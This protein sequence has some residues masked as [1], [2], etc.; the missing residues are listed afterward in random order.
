MKRNL[1]YITDCEGPICLNDNAQ[2]LSEFYLP[3][4]D[5]FFEQ[6]SK[7]DDIK[8]L[9][10]KT[11]DYSAGDTLRL[12]LPFFRAYGVSNKGIEYFVRNIKRVDFLNGVKKAFLYLH[13]DGFPVFIVST[14]YEQF[15]Y[16]VADELGIDQENVY[17]TKLDLDEYFFSKQEKE[18]IKDFLYEIISLPKI[19]V[20][21]NDDGN[22]DILDEDTRKTFERLEDIFWKE[23]NGM[24]CGLLLKDV[25]VMNANRKAEA[26]KEIL[27]KRKGTQ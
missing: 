16:I 20:P 19:N 10:G 14:S 2:E 5:I 1:V 7:Y 21:E 22:I 23:M 6:I 17:C 15:V 8:C 13:L 27:E 3:H 9:Y 4:G 11:P 26:V 25:I 12:I 18:V 24:E